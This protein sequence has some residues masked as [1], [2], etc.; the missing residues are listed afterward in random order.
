MRINNRSIQDMQIFGDPFCVYQLCLLK[1]DTIRKKSAP[2][3]NV[4]VLKIVVFVHGFQ[5]CLVDFIAKL[6][7]V[8]LM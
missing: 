4:R 6:H 8:F 5:A 1:G 7:L 3:S 2:K